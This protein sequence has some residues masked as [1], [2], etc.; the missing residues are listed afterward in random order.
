MIGG[1]PFSRRHW[2]AT[3]WA[4]PAAGRCNGMSNMDFSA[5]RDTTNMRRIL[6]IW[7][8]RL[9]TDRLTRRAPSAFD[10]P[11]IVSGRANNALYVHAL[12]ARAERLGLYKD[13]PLANARAMV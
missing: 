13:Q 1:R 11:L 3:G 7:L 9:P 6:A 5:K 10:A 8:P 12:E 4:P 2:C